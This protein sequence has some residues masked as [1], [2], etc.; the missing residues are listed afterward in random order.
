VPGIASVL[1]IRF[2]RT[3]TFRLTALYAAVFGASVLAILAFIYWSTAQSI[4]R[5]TEEAILDEIEIL[6][7]RFQSGGTRALINAISDRAAPEALGNGVYLLTTADH[8]RLAGNLK[9][10]PASAPRTDPWL[11][12]HPNSGEIAALG[13]IFDLPDGLS[14]LVGRRIAELERFHEVML[15]A[16]LWALVGTLALGIGGGLAVSRHTLHRIDA[17]NLDAA[18]VMRGDMAHRMATDGS[19]DEFDRLVHTLNEMLTQ[20]EQLMTGIRTV[21]NN[22]AHDLRSPLTRMR[23]ELERAVGHGG[24]AEDLRDTCAQVMAEA[25]NLLV[26]FNAM[27]SIAEAE[28]GMA[29]AEMC[30]V[31]LTAIAEDIADLYGPVAED[32]GLTLEAAAV[33]GVV[34]AG[35]RELLFQAL[36]NLVDNAIKYTPPPGRVRIEVEALGA[37]VEL[38]VVDSGFGIPAEERENVRQRFI[39]LDESRSTP[40]NGLG[41][42]LVS[43]IA[44]LHRA[45]LVLCDAEPRGLSAILR[46]PV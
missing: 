42:S 19:G 10:W 8:R 6:Q 44:R 46:F 45:Q 30:P 17:I 39:R 32:Q 12:F 7:Q 18:R 24:A 16:M 20:I 15:E 21:A 26:T 41:L 14:L 4:E 36:T 9:Q 33:P 34:V 31:D 40:G 27:L 3:S 2:L 37:V 23:G 11:F 13:R 35:N 43:A 1:L 5:Q 22:I 28:A 29:V 25:D 38:R